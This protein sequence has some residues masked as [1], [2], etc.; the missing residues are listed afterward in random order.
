MFAE[1]APLIL[2]YTNAEHLDFASFS[3][4]KHILKRYSKIFILLQV[5]DTY[6][7]IPMVGINT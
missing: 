6:T 2:L 4:L 3:V 5:R 1:V 7:E